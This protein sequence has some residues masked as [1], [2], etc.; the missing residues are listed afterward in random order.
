MRFLLGVLFSVLLVQSSYAG[1]PPRARDLGI[2]FDGSPGPWNAITDV[3]GVMVGHHT[4]MEDLPN[5]RKV[6]T[7]VTAV[8]PLG[9]DT[10][11]QPVF[12]AWFA[13]NGNGEMTGTTWLEESGQLEGPIML[14]NTHSVGMVHHA[15]I[16]WR[17]R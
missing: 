9:R 16:V 4:L 14:T 12:G 2:R 8:L 10:L 1:E 13:L 7:G 5:G 17:V 3:A 11:M 6:R 15:T